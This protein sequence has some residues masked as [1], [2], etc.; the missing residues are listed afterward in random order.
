MRVS[1]L[2]AAWM[3]AHAACGQINPDSLWRKPFG[4]N[5][6]CV[7][8]VIR[9]TDDGG[10]LLMGTESTPSGDEAHAVRLD[11][12]G[13]LLWSR[14]YC[15]SWAL[16]AHDVRQA[17]DGQLLFAGTVSALTADSQRAFLIRTTDQGDTLWMRVF[18]DS[19]C[20]IQA[21]QPTSDGGCVLAG[22]TTNAV[23]GQSDMTLVKMDFLGIPIWRHCYNIPGDE[24][25]MALQ[26]TPDGGWIIAGQ[27][28]SEDGA[29]MLHLLRTDSGG[30]LRWARAFP[31]KG[32]LRVFDVQCVS[33]D[34]FVVAGWRVIPGTEPCA[35]FL[36]RTDA[37]G[38]PLWFRK[39]LADCETF[40]HVM[41]RVTPSGY[42]VAT[43]VISLGDGNRLLTL[44]KMDQDGELLY[45]TDFSG[46]GFV[47]RMEDRGYRQYLT[48]APIRNGLRD[49][50]LD[51]D[52]PVQES[53]DIRPA[54]PLPERSERHGPH[55]SF[56]NVYWTLFT[57]N[58][59]QPVSVTA[60]DSRGRLIRTVADNDYCAGSHCEIFD[61]WNLPPGIYFLRVE[62]RNMHQTRKVVLVH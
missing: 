11:S 31:I 42:L 34:G 49:F 28:M 18:G 1:F 35:F 39:Y 2:I 16:K 6:D 61:G 25:A 27:G 47:N 48:A 4:G 26:P 21:I 44:L 45:H 9:M 62:T 51:P 23:S 32:L 24:W 46:M 20:G 54:A 58:H 8:D 22:W 37:N 19:A 41:L 12:L 30:S 7:A 13:R 40:S 57:L 33:G 43:H 55:D 59:R 17:F 14:G 50:F 5:S 38:N 60:Y 3:V 29:R 15:A 53:I 36:T 10:Y 56:G 52:L